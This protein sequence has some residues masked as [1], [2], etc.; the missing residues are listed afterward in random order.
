[1]NQ[2]IQEVRKD[3]IHVL[4]CEY[5]YNCTKW[6][7]KCEY[8]HTFVQSWMI[9]KVINVQYVE[10]PSFIIHGIENKSGTHQPEEIALESSLRIFRIM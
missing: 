3:M 10:Q 5:V 9:L 2:L 4:H 6:E 8:V 7:V 1:M